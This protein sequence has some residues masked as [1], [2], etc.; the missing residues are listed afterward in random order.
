MSSAGG[1][2]NT[3]LHIMQD[4]EI[5]S[6]WQH[7]PQGWCRDTLHSCL[8]PCHVQLYRTDQ[9][10]WASSSQGNL[11]LDPVEA[12]QK[13]EN[14][15]SSTYWVDITNCRGNAG[16]MTTPH[17]TNRRKLHLFAKVCL[18]HK[19]WI[20]QLIVCSVD[21]QRSKGLPWGTFH[22]SHFQLSC[23]YILLTAQTA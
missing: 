17:L 7:I 10:L 9:P 18:S 14:V 8:W 12:R 16:T 20:V 15:Q 11:N 1:K 4:V 5:S 22:H 6:S 3:A 13:S 19:R 23:L 2:T 21:K